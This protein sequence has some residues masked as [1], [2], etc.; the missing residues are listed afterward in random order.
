MGQ[1]LTM[2]LVELGYRVAALD[3]DISPL[4]ELAEAHPATL[5]C[6]TVDVRSPMQVQRATAAVLAEWGKVDILVNNSAV[7]VLGGFEEKSL[8][9]IRREFELNYFGYLHLIRAVLPIMKARGYGIIHNVSL[10]VALT[11]LPGLS[12][13]TSTRGAVESLTRT[14]RQEL[15]EAGVAVTLMR[16]PLARGPWAARMGI[17]RDALA[18]PAEVGR[19]LAR[20]IL[21]T[22]A[23]IGTEDLVE[24]LLSSV[25]RLLTRAARTLQGSE[26]QRAR[27]GP[28]LRRGVI[29][30]R[31]VACNP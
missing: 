29:G 14:L 28:K 9:Q 6:H 11:G 30:S 20:Q 3:L 13:Y 10:D 23:V 21:A 31:Q 26:T 24:I 1:F 2:A 19:R 8:D 17:P 4:T 18:D 22:S 7:A 25:T 12:S 27:P 16:T 15:K 5:R